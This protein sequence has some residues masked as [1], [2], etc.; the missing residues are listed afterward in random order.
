MPTPLWVLEW[1]VSSA[2]HLQE[3][4]QAPDTVRALRALTVQ[5]EATNR[6]NVP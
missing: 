3:A 5:R 6:I 1:P 4:R 2:R